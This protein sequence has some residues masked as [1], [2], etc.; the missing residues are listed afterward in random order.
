MIR[1]ATGSFGKI[2][3]KA[4]RPAYSDFFLDGVVREAASERKTW[5]RDKEKMIKDTPCLT[6]RENGEGERA[7]AQEKDGEGGTAR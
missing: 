7:K 6:A 1:L 4:L 5:A 3:W 2:G